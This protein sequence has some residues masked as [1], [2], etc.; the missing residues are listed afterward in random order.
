MVFPKIPPGKSQIVTSRQHSNSGHFRTGPQA[1]RT[2]PY[3]TR[4]S[5]SK[6][7]SG[8]FALTMRQLVT[9]PNRRIFATVGSFPWESGLCNE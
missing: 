6:N 4:R 7:R 3:G 1:R 2:E 9:H 8:Y 5:T